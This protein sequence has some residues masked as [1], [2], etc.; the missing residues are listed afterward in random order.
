MKKKKVNSNKAEIKKKY[1][2]SNQW[3]S[4]VLEVQMENHWSKHTKAI[5]KYKL[6]VHTGILSLSRP[7]RGEEM[8]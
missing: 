5:L 3:T 1:V 2:N 6:C 7:K 4:G 8:A